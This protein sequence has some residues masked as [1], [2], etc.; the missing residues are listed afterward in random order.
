MVS[1]AGADRRIPTWASRVVSGL[2]RDRPVVVT[3]EDLTQRLT[4]AGCG[5]DPDSAIRELRRIGWLVQLPVKGTWAFIPPGEAAISDPYLPLRSWL[6]RDQNAGFMLAGA[7]AAWHLGYLD[8]QPDGRIPI[9]LPPAKRLP[10]GLASYVSVVRIPWNAADTALLAPRPALLVRRR[11]DLVAWATGLPALGPEALL[12]QIATRPASFGPWADLVPHLDDLVA[13]CSDERLER[14]LSGRPTSAWQRASYL[15]DSGVTGTRPGAAGQAAHRSDAGDSIHHR[16][17]PR[18]WREC[19][20]SRVSA[21]RRARRTA[22]ARDRQGVTVA[23]LTRALVARHALGRAEAY[24]AALLDVAQ[25]HLLYLLSQTVQFGDNRLVFKG[26]TSLRKCRLG[27]VGR[28][29][30][31]LDFSA[32]DDEVVLEVCELID[33]AR[34]G[35]FEFGVQ[36]TRGDGRHWQLRVRHTELGEPRI[37]ASVEFARRPLALPSELLAFIQLPI[38]KAYGFGLPTLPVVAE[39]EACAEKLARYRRVALARDLYD[40]NHFAS[41]TIDEPLVRRLWVLKVWGDVVDDR[42]GTRPLRVEDVLAARSEHDFQPDS[43][44]VLTR[45]VAMAAWEARVRKRFAFLTDLDAD[46]Q[47]WAACDERHRREVENALAVLRS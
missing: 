29:S 8:R 22:A 16:A 11:L 31:D 9:W 14:L 21:C 42:R 10:D 46:E 17:Q 32:P 1:P 41:R 12:V 37:V 18:P 28:F 38:H 26:G 15:L 33:G 20:G 43:I 7:S 2:A 36:S 5:R 39:A 19:L 6:A 44:G 45:P 13:D 35:G 40:L 4:E 23:G 30:T 3:K 47:R 27:N 25:D 24:D 34:V